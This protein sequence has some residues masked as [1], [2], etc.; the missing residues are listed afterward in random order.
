[1]TKSNRDEFSKETKR[2]L[3]GR[4]GHVCSFPGCAQPTSGPSAEA[5]NSLAN[6]GEACHIRAAAS[7]RGARRYDPSMTSEERRALDNGIWMCRTHGKLIDS[8]EATYTVEQLHQWR[9]EAEK[10]AAQLLRDGSAAAL[11]ASH[12]YG[13]PRT[14]S[15]KFVGREVEITQLREFLER[16]QAVRI[17]AAV[18]GLP[19]IGKTELA[20]QLVYQLSRDSVFAGGIFWFDAEDPDL[21]PSWGGAIADALGVPLGPIEERAAGSLRMV[22]QQSLPTLLVLDNVESWSAARQ[23]S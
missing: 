1:M 3:A 11:V 20:L 2:I 18:E 12:L 22:S 15:G 13:T 8:D 17:A 6:L 14:P 9:R 7:G 5:E 23:P 4:A 19:G 21:T 10:R 16:S